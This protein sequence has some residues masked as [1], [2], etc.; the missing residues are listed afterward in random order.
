MKFKLT[1]LFIA[2]TNICFAQH[3]I[4]IENKI[5]IKTSP[6]SL[7]DPFGGYSYRIG[8]EFKISRNIAATIEYGRYFSIG[9][10]DKINLKLNTRGFIIKP[11]LKMYLNNRKQTQGKY[12]ALEFLFKKIN[13]DYKDSIKLSSQPV[14]QKKY[15][16]FKNIYCINAKY[17]K[18]NIYTN[19][20]VFEWYIGIGL[21]FINGHTSLSK[22][23]SDGVLTGENH[24]DI[25]GKLQ[26]EISHIYPNLN[27]GIKIGYLL[28]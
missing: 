22:E 17:G 23:E 7:I 11:E 26:R 14:F 8:T 6:L 27:A 2:F 4:P 10:S 1:T 19:K 18:L 28:K 3:E 13:F 16:I 12:I 15:N 5:S 9:K 20:F 24:G 21:R 25:I